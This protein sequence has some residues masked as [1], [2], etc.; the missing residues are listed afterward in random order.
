MYMRFGEEVSI[1]WHLLSLSHLLECML[2]FFVQFI[3][4]KLFSF[5]VLIYGHHKGYCPSFFEISIFLTNRKQFRRLF[6][7]FVEILT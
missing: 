1:Y 4:S 7:M 3:A 5:H 2:G 6:F